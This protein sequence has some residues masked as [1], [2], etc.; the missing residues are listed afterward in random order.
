MVGDYLENVRLRIEHSKVMAFH[1]QV[2]LDQSR[3]LI[4]DC[5]VWLDKYRASSDE[6]GTPPGNSESP[7]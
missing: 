2:A 7:L 1:S 6:A 3:D 5:K 4:N